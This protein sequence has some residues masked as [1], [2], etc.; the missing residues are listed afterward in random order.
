[1]AAEALVGVYRG[2]SDAL[3]DRYARQ[4][5]RIAVEDVQTKSDLNYHRH[6]ERDPEKRRAI[7]AEF[8]N[9]VADRA[10]MREFLLESSMIASLTRAAAIA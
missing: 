7:W 8:K 6:R 2:G 10:R 4:R 3:L 1:M 9:T 5:R